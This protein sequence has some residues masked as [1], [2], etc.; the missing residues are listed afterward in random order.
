MSAV[1]KQDDQRVFTA[2]VKSVV[3]NYGVPGNIADSIN[4]SR[5]YDIVADRMVYMLSA[6]IAGNDLPETV[7]AEYPADW[8][9]AV[10]ARFFPAW[11]LK[12]MP[13]QVKRVSVSGEVLYPDLVLPKGQS[14]FRVIPSESRGLLRV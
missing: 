11:L 12:K 10:K 14:V 3:V 1:F 13:V 7:F 6:H 8:W 4:T 2:Q 9:Q 5:A